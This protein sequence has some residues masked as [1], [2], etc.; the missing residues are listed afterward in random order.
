MELLLNDEP[1]VEI[2]DAINAYDDQIV[3]VDRNIAE[4]LDGYA[5]FARQARAADT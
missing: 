3:R 4:L 5:A 2:P 1:L